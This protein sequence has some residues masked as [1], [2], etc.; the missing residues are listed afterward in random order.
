ML[1]GDSTCIGSICRIV[2]P[3]ADHLEQVIEKLL[4]AEKNLPPVK[5]INQGR[6]G[7]YIRGLLKSGRY[8]RD[9]AP[10]KDIDFVLIRYGANDRHRL[11]DF[12]NEFPRDYR[13]ADRAAAQG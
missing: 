10:L 3:Q 6:D 13:R 9:I 1:L 8:D 4:A 2:A 12:A 7:E 5:V 11:K